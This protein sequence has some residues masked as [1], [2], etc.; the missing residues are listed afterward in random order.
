[1]YGIDRSKGIVL[2]RSALASRVTTRR[3][4]KSHFEEVTEHSDRSRVTALPPTVVSR[5]VYVLYRQVVQLN[6]T[7]DR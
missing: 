3:A 6:T 5:L 2:I 1:M 7:V 4:K